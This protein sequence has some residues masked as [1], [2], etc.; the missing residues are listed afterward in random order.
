MEGPKT[1][2]MLQ[3]GQS[4]YVAK[5]NENIYTCKLMNLGIL[6]KTRVTVIRKAPFGGA[7]Y[8][9]IDNYQM[10]MRPNEAASIY[11]K[12]IQDLA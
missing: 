11:I 6:P 4:A 7:L 5:L 9:K 2:D 12:D 3:P 10:A 1:L 8:I